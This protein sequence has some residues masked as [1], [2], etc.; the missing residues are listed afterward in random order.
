MLSFNVQTLRKLWVTISKKYHAKAH[1]ICGT[2]V[3]RYNHNKNIC[4][5][6][7]V[8]NWFSVDLKSSF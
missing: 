1:S 6:K 8:N 2:Y 4:H 7:N 5:D 3:K